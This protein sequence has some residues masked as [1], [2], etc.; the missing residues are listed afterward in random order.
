MILL[1]YPHTPNSIVLNI[2][3]Y[4]A[5]N[6][7]KNIIDFKNERENGWEK[8]IICCRSSTEGGEKGIFSG[9]Y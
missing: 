6:I 9:M 8:A 5:I 7:F 1:C 4:Y 3:Q 2:F